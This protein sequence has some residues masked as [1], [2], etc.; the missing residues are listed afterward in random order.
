MNRPVIGGE[1]DADLDQ[2]TR[3]ERRD[4][5]W[6]NAIR[7]GLPRYP[8]WI[9]CFSLAFTGVPIGLVVLIGGVATGVTS[10]AVV[11]SVSMCL[12]LCSLI[13]GIRIRRREQVASVTSPPRPLRVR[14]KRRGP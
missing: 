4:E 1:D 7:W 14:P 8:R 5:F 12:G 2:H 9:K 11:G 10:A 3:H 6:E 13:V